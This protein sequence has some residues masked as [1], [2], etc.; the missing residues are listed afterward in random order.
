MSAD[1]RTREVYERTADRYVEAIGTTI[2]TAVESP[3]DIAALRAFADRCLAAPVLDAGCGPGRAGRAVAATGAA[4]IGLD[5]ARTMVEVAAQG[6]DGL[7]AVQ[8]S[9]THLPFSS[10][11]FGGVVA[12]YS[13]I[14]L[15]PQRLAGVW[16]D[17]ARVLQPGAPVLVAFQAGDGREITR[18]DAHGSGQTLTSYHHDPGNIAS[19]LAT[20]GLV[21]IDTRVRPAELDHEST[22]QAI[23]S[24][25]APIDRD[26]STRARLR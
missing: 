17:V 16:L 11:A 12:W 5:L 7:P 13:V 18:Q 4:V 1:D 3:A 23:I 9:V 25:T 20:A 15:A 21:G 6:D 14:H 2:S 8:G 24:A 22:P 19:G 10:A 26:G